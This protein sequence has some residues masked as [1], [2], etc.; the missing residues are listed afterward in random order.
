MDFGN[1]SLT[2][3]MALAAGVLGQSL[4][5]HLRVP[6]IVILLLTGVVLGPDVLGV[7]DP[8]RV[9]HAL[10]ELIG[11]A[12]AVILFEGGLNLSFGRLRREAV[13]I[14]RL[15]TLGAILTAALGTA[16]ARLILQ[17]D[18]S[19][20]VLFGTLVI[21]TGPTVVTPLL[22][23]I[24]VRTNVS[25]ILE[26]EGV[27]I[28]AVGAIIAVVALQIV[29]Q[30][31]GTSFA[32][33]ALGALGRFLL[34]A[35]FGA[36]G[37]AAI[38]LLL[39]PRRLVPEGLENVLTLALVWL[40]FQVSNA[41]LPESGIATVTVAGV[42]VGN[43]KTRVSRDLIEFKEQLTVLLIG[44][45]FVLLAADVRLDDVRS[46][47]WPGF[48]TVL[49]LMFVVR[50]IV[51]LAC[52]VGV[53]LTWRERAFLSWLAPR[54]IVA[55]A[56]ASLFAQ[57]L[58]DAGRTGGTELRALVF[59][60]IAMTV[61]LQ[62]LTGGWIARW[63]GLLR[64]SN[65]GFAILGAG[66]LGRAV[67]RE[68]GARRPSITFLDS[69]AQSCRAAE[70]EGFRVTYG[71]ALEESV[72]AR[73]QV[74]TR[75][76]CIALTVNEEVNLLFARH[77]R[78]E[79]RVSNIYVALQRGNKSVSPERVEE[80]G[81]QVL[82]GRPRDLELWEVRFRRG[83]ALV[84]RWRLESPIE[85]GEFEEESMIKR[86]LLLPLAYKRGKRRY[87]MGQGFEPKK[88]D[89]FS[90]AIIEDERSAVGD[91]LQVRG[92]VPVT[93][94]EEPTEQEVVPVRQPSPASTT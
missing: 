49:A 52:T 23:R 86:E 84:E 93:E 2:I 57:N 51:I 76:A 46:L 81:G 91:W 80:V 26:A 69:N 68:L 5:R 67:G 65:F 30:P 38:G 37:G 53:K 74:D 71:N 20:S 31:S 12:V 1:S 47:G 29:L 7:M 63:L 10:H 66:D 88:G 15:I 43:V 22:R 60:V 78:E 11:F 82:F 42:I 94:T 79:F 33:G 34:G 21:V 70:E 90:F 41:I 58:Q 50:P 24:R 83:T 25:T 48:F 14:R 17:W 8:H 44:M 27:F 18:W 28:D 85:K 73:A 4:A 54:G 61:V 13:V 35:L 16:A 87:V 72:L 3:A 56:I 19:L 6:G 64:Q 62:G 45:L 77:L 36:I 9:H 75:S 59:L 55:A 89:E 92:W 40:L 32:Y 39:R